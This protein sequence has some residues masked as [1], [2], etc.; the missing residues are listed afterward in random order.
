MNPVV[1]KWTFGI[2]VT[3]VGMGGTIV[4][5]WVLSIIMNILKKIMPLSRGEK[6][7]QPTGAVG[8]QK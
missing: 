5:L 7:P 1:D 4:T 6:P 2:T 8:G 3:I